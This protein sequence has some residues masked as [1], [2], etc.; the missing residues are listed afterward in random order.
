MEFAPGDGAPGRAWAHGRPFVVAD[1]AADPSFGR[2]DA[3]RRLGLKSGVAVPALTDD[4]PLAVLTF[5]ST[6]RRAGTARLERTLGAIGRDV[7]AFLARRRAQLSDRTLS[8]RELEVLRL[9]AEGRSGPEIAR[10]LVVAPSTIKTHFEH[11]YEKLG[12]GDRAGAVAYALRA[13]IIE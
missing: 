7:G 12:V 9:A 10:H 2:P 8:P 11:I 3:A 13:G 5:Y 6:D 4:G 1:V